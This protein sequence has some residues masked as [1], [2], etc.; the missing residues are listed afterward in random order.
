M[1]PSWRDIY[2]GH[3]GYG[4]TQFNNDWIAVVAARCSVVCASAPSQ[5]GDDAGLVP[6]LAG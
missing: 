5:E 3:G 2:I 1:V 6:L 4:L